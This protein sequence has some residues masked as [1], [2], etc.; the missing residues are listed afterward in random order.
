MF[1]QSRIWVKNIFLFG[2]ILSGKISIFNRWNKKMLAVVLK[3][4]KVKKAILFGSYAKGEASK[5][6]I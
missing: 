3:N 1:Y 6:V 4:T 2:G 5:K